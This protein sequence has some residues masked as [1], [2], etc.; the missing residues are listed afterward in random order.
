FWASVIAEGAGG[1]AEQP[2]KRQLAASTRAQRKRFMSGLPQV[3]FSSHWA[4]TGWPSLDKLSRRKTSASTLNLMIRRD[5][6]AIET[7]MTLGWAEPKKMYH[8]VP[9]GASLGLGAFL[10]GMGGTPVRMALVP[11]PVRWPP[12]RTTSSSQPA[13]CHRSLSPPSEPC[14]S[15]FRAFSATI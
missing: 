3:Q 14:P 15:G 12:K 13:L 11:D 8:L 6:S 9:V 5:P 10:S 1:C 7:L 2:N 4:F